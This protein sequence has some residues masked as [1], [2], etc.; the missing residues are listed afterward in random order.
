MSRQLLIL[1]I[2]GLFL[3]SSP[4]RESHSHSGHKK[5]AV[6]VEE[7]AAESSIYAVDE[8]ETS[9]GEEDIFPLSRTNVLSDDMPAM[10]E[11]MDHMDHSMEG[12]MDHKMPEVEIAK[13]E[14]IS[15]QKKGYGAAVGITIFAGLIFGV[16]HFKRPNQ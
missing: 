9:S 14:W 2:L 15:P 16:L 10:P 7:P 6:E 1:L 13:R 8:E 12:G 4:V 5:K 11:A 3:F